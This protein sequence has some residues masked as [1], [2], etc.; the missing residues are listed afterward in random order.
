MILDSQSVCLCTVLLL[1]M[2]PF[3]QQVVCLYGLLLHVLVVT[4]S[5]I[6]IHALASFP[7]FIFYM[8]FV[9]FCL[10]SSNLCIID[11]T[12]PAASI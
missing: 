9:G 10:A 3:R 7:N 2:P 1:C 6:G 11:P 5:Y 8:L 4:S 12:L